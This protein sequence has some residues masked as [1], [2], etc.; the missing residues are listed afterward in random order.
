VIGRLAGRVRVEVFVSKRGVDAFVRRKLPV[1]ND[2]AVS[3]EGVGAF[4]KPAARPEDV[5]TPQSFMR[6]HPYAATFR[7]EHCLSRQKLSKLATSAKDKLYGR[8]S[9]FG[10]CRSCSQ[11]ELVIAILAAR[12]YVAKRMR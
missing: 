3:P 1:I 6:C 7:A 11:G 12:K 8:S 10:R 5:L 9:E 2:S 4:D